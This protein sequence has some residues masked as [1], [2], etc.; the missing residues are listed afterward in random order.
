MEGKNKEKKIKKN[1]FI[2]KE[3]K[4]RKYTDIK[5]KKLLEIFNV[6]IGRITKKK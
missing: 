5:I 4:K 1:T 6:S 2:I 3:K